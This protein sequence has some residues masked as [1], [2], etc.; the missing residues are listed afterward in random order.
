MA[1]VDCRTLKAI[2]QQPRSTGNAPMRTESSIRASKDALR[3]PSCELP[4]QRREAIPSIGDPVSEASSS[5]NAGGLPVSSFIG[6]RDSDRSTTAALFTL[7]QQL[8]PIWGSCGLAEL[9]AMANA[10]Q[11]SRKNQDRLKLG[12]KHAIRIVRWMWV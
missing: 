5:G 8:R 3:R 1:S 6:G 7:E 2:E 10:K 9:V 12:S 4:R 11:I